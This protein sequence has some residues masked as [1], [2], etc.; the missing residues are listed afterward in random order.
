MRAPRLALC[1]LALALAATPFVTT[2]AQGRDTTRR[3][4]ASGRGGQ[5]N[6]QRGMMMQR[7]KDEL[8]GDLER[9]KKHVV[10]YVNVAPDSMLGFRTTP[11]VRTY[12]QQL[13]HIASATGG[14]IGSSLGAAPMAAQGD[15]ARLFTNKAVLRD[16]VV[17]QYD[18]A[19][20]AVR[21]AQPQA[22]RAEKSMFGMTRTGTRWVQGALE[23]GTWTLGQTVPYLRMNK[24]TPPSYLPF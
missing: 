11:G 7:M 20:K 1:T 10:D 2:H 8:I 15:T 6:A 19:I 9:Q 18:Y 21:E 12:A 13:H 14:I 16:F 17:A 3:R 4:P 22:L 5:D 24:V 23:H